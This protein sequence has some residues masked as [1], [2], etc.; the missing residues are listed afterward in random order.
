[1]IAVARLIGRQMAREAF[2]GQ[3]AANDSEAMAQGFRDKKT[4]M[5]IKERLSAH[6]L[7]LSEAEFGGLGD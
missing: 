4:K 5:P 7:H 2:S 6:K 1:V 3:A